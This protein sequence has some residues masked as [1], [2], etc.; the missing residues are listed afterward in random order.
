MKT[1]LKAAAIFLTILT[2]LSVL[3][4]CTP[5]QT[6][7]T[8]AN[9]PAANSENETSSEQSGETAQESGTSGI[10]SDSSENAYEERLSPSSR[11]DAD[12]LAESFVDSAASQ[13][14]EHSLEHT[15]HDADNGIVGEGLTVWFL[16]VGQADSAFVACEGYT[17]LIDGGN[18]SDSSLIY[19]FLDKRNI[20]H[21]DYIVATH[22]HEDHV[23]GLAGALNFATVGIA[24]CPVLDYDSRAFGS[25]VKYL[26][27]Q[28]AN[29]TV[30]SPGVVFMLGSATV[31]ILAPVKQYDSPNNSS[32]VLK[33]TY[34]ETSFL[35]TGDA[36]RESEQDMLEIGCELS[37]TV[38]KVGHHGSDTSTTYPFLREIMP[39]YAVISCGKN[40]SYG[41]PHENLLSRLRDA[42]VMLYRTDMQGDIICVS[43]GK[44]VSFF[45]ERNADIQTNPTISAEVLL[46]APSW[47][48]HWEAQLEE[49]PAMEP[50]PSIIEGNI[51]ESSLSDMSSSTSSYSYIGNVNSMKFHKP[52]CHSL[53]AE[54][55]RVY[56][57]T[58]EAAILAGYDPC[59]NCNS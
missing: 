19:S 26:G 34:G 40:N 29:I 48:N 42:D 9:E 30:P 50:A 45:A 55:N 18:A 15:S 44:S 56:I 38:L 57:E 41:H 35:F 13:R 33:I 51:G 5:A 2:L 28:G 39:Q 14:N 49:A 16:D 10:Q 8:I 37:A 31:E 46:E 24:Y 58:W 25:F 6:G 17:M 3:V 22:A 36:E 11:T 53:P 27:E 47:Q 7:S 43:D 4:A 23:G 20:T 54:R 52:D 12:S 1:M 32:I 59:G 21:L